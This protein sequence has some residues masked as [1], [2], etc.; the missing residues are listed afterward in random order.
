M[1]IRIRISTGLIGNSGRSSVDAF[2][3]SIVS[4][5]ILSLDCNLVLIFLSFSFYGNNLQRDS[6]IFEKM[7]LII[8]LEGL[9]YVPQVIPEHVR[10]D[11]AIR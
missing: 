4:G 9:C 11:T 5:S 1:F 3:S 8:I 2:C 7:L 10:E 6:R